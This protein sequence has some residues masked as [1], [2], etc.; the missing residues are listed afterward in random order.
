MIGSVVYPAAVD[1]GAK[2]AS[3]NRVRDRRWIAIA[4]LVISGA[5]VFWTLAGQVS[6][7]LHDDELYSYNHFVA[8][9]PS[10]IWGQYGANDHILYEFLAWLLTS[11]TGDHSNATLRFWDVTA[12]LCSVALLGRWL[13]LRLGRWVAVAFTTAIAASPIFVFLGGEGRGYGLNFLSSASILVAADGYRRAREPRWLAMFGAGALVG[14]WTDPIMLLPVIGMAGVLAVWPAGRRGV[15]V[16]LAV[17]L[18]MSAIFYAPTISALLSAHKQLFGKPL[19]VAG[20]ITGPLHDQLQPTLQTLL[21][22]L[23]G[24]PHNG[25][26]S[27]MLAD[28]IV[29][30][31]PPPTVRTGA[32]AVAMDAGQPSLALELIAAALVLGGSAVLYVRRERFLAAALVVPGVFSYLAV[33]I[34]GIGARARFFS[35]SLAPLLSISLVAL[36]GLCA[37][38]AARRRILRGAASLVAAAAYVLTLAKAADL[39]KIATEPLDPY[40]H[41][42]SILLAANSGPIYSNLGWGPSHYLPRGTITPKSP[43]ELETIFCSGAPPFTYYE[44]DLHDEPPT[45]CLTR[46]GAE[47]IT[48]QNRRLTPMAVWLLPSHAATVPEPQSVA[49]TAVPSSLPAAGPARA[50]A[51]INWRVAGDTSVTLRVSIDGGPAVTMARG[52]SQGQAIAPWITRGHRYIFR[53]YSAADPSKLLGQATVNRS[54]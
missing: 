13:W 43:S 2:R 51:T 44:D 42:A 6:L 45:S 29:D 37:T 41:V 31:P 4:L 21:P 52:G 49:V 32:V 39:S 12:A 7:G 9:G 27:A 50:S 24:N 10:A 36:V 28:T 18:A 46:R 54:G 34:T 5:V 53:L 8:Q 14:I 40:D 38:V 47:K 19:P 26:T 25:L 48:I 33:E 3:A 22:G 11:V 30:E 23:S 20:F 17:V 15:L 1:A 35:F 16:T